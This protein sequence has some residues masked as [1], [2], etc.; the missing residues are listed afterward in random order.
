YFGNAAT[1]LQPG[2][3]SSCHG[4]YSYDVGTW[5][6]VVLNSNCS[7]AGGCGV[8]S[9]QE[10][11]LRADLAAHT[12]TC[13]VAYMHHPRFSSGQIGS[14]PTMQPLWQA[15][16]DNGGDLVLAGHDH[17]YERFAPQTPG[18]QA[19]SNWGI[20]EFVVGT[21][22][23]NTSALGTIKANSEVRNTNT[24][25]ILK[26]VLRPTG[27]DWQFI[28]ISGSTFTDSG[29]GNCHGVP[30]TADVGGAVATGAGPGNLAGLPVAMAVASD[31]AGQPHRGQGTDPMT[32]LLTALPA[33]AFVGSWRSSLIRR[34]GARHVIPP[35]R[36]NHVTRSS[37]YVGRSE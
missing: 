12:N 27:Y 1:P 3:P 35:T 36:P 6:I 22:G 9:A 16:Y 8:G 14:F 17:N 10:K 13:S 34:R 25:G 2:C 32:F 37:G 31:P 20:R 30:G 18:G 28:P 19:D 33:A 26:L 5:H 15:F 29:S 4:Y 21:G 24:F 11:W 7:Q 23:R